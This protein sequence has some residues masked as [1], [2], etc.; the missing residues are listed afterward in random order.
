MQKL[1]LTGNL[2]TGIRA[3]DEQH[4]ALFALANDVLQDPDGE[5]P[6]AVVEALESLSAYVDFHFASEEH[7]M[8]VSGFPREAA[9]RAW[10]EQLRG[11]VL[12][13]REQVQA[14][15]PTRGLVARVQVLM[16][17]WLVYHIGH[18]DAELAQ[19]L[20]CRPE[21]DLPDLPA[22]KGMGVLIDLDGARLERRKRGSASSGA[23]TAANVA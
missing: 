18:M 9:H 19:H 1:V 22:L 10:H 12:S 17:D 21:I 2:L 3:I 11:E 13:L 6:P 4:R 16:E 7:A 5:K 15:G 20:A 8:A 14:E 23:T